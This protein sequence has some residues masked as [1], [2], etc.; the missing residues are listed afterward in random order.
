MGGGRLLALVFSQEELSD[1]GLITH[2]CVLAL[3]QG[4]DGR[5]GLLPQSY[6]P[7]LALKFP[8]HIKSP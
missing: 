1:L 2:L 7:G 8:H 5:D 6:P 4:A 3:E